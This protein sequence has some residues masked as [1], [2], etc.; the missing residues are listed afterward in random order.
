MKMSRMAKTFCDGGLTQMATYGN[1]I[2]AFVHFDFI[3]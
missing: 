3:N 2:N 1:V